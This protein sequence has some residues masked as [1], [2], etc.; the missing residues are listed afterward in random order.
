MADPAQVIPAAAPR[1]P[2]AMTPFE[3][4]AGTVLAAATIA[5]A[6]WLLWRERRMPN[7]GPAAWRKPTAWLLVA[8]GALMACGS[9]LEPAATP[10]LFL[11]VWM[12]ALLGIALAALIACADLMLVRRRGLAARRELHAARKAALQAELPSPPNAHD[13]WRRPSNN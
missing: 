6:L 11:I 10:R 4:G 3:R 1:P 5:A 8:V 13:R 12:A 2:L 7:L 9:W